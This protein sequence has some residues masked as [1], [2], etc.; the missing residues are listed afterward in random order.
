[1]SEAM[2][3]SRS[4]YSITS[5]VSLLD[6]LTTVEFVTELFI[7]AAIISPYSLL[8]HSSIVYVGKLLFEG[9]NQERN[10]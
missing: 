1:M 8:S 2:V 3:W 9:S 6:L 4:A 7:K 5:K 10:E